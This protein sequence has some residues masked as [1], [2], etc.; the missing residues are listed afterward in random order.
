MKKIQVLHIQF[1]EIQ[2]KTRDAHKLRGYFGNLFKE[3]SALLHNNYEGGKL[4]YQYPLVQYKVIGGIPTLLALEEGAHLLAGLFLQ[5]KEL[6]ID[7]ITY[8][9]HNKSMKT[10]EVGIGHSTELYEYKFQT[11]W[12]ALNQTNHKLFLE[13]TD[14][15]RTIMLNKIL[16]GNVLSLLKGLNIRLNENEHLMA[17]T[18]VSEKSTKFK[19]KDMIAFMGSFIINAI[20]PDGIGLGKAVSRG[21]GTIKKQ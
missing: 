11:L 7:G 8:T 9:I 12:M 5:I 15:Q 18:N 14:E 13:A 17:K 10:E 3:H 2:L 4:K 1:P 19:D 16:L 20:L 6:N 21:F